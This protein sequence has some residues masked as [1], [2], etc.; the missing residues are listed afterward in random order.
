MVVVEIVVYIFLFCI[1]KVEMN[2]CILI[3]RK[4]RIDMKAIFELKKKTLKFDFEF[5]KGR[6]QREV[7]R[8]SNGSECIMKKSDTDIC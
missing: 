4:L 1:R 7:N 3:Y 6:A 2:I 8:G 5:E